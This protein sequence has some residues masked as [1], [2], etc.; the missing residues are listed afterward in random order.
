MRN[1]LLILFVGVFQLYASDTYSQNTRLT[2]DLN[3]VPVA[4]VLEKI[5][6]NSEFYFLYNAKLVD[7]KREVSII[8]K[9][10]KICDI[11]ASLFSGTGVYYK[12]FDRQIILTPNE[13]TELPATLPQQLNITGKVTDASTGEPMPGVNIQVKG[14]TLGTISDAEG[15]YSLSVT[16]RNATL[17]FSF[18]GYTNQEISLNGRTSVDVTLTSEVLGLEEVIVIGYGTVKK[19]DLTGSVIRV[20]AQTPTLRSQAN[21]Q[22]TDMISGSVPGFYMTQGTSASGGASTLE[23]RGLN[24]LL[25]NTNPLF[26]VDGVIYNGDIKDI[27]P[28]DIAAIDILKDASASAVFGSRSASGVVIITTTKGEIGK[29]KISF[30]S[31]LGISESTRDIKPFQGEKYFDFKQSFWEENVPHVNAPYY[32]TNPYKLPSGI[33]IDEWLK[34]SANPDADPTLEWLSRLAFWP[35]EV[36]NYKEGKTVDWYDEVMQKGI[37]QNYDLSITGGTENVSYYWSVGYLNN[38]GIVVGDKFST[39]R[40]RLNVDIKVADFINIGM[41]TQFSDR[42]QSQAPANL[43]MLYRMS[44]YGSEYNIDGT[45]RYLPAEYNP[46]QNPLLEYYYNDV[47]YKTISLNSTLYSQIKLPFGITYRLTF[48]PRFD[49]TQNLFFKPTTLETGFGSR[50][51]IKRCDWMLDNLLK[52]N[53]KIGIHDF[54]L[55]LLYS[56]EKNQMWSTSSSNRNFMPNDLLSYHGL[57]LG[58]LPAVSS[59]DTYSTGDAAMA[60]L[61]YILLEKYFLTLS[62][63]RDGFSAFGQENPRAFFPAFAVAWRISKEDFFK[64]SWI[65]QLKLRLSLGINGNR[66]I[67][68]YSALANLAPVYYLDASSVQIGLTSSN[69][70]NKGL[71]WERTESINYGMDIGLI[72]NRII[73]SVDYYN[74]TTKD[75]LMNRRLPIITGY[76]NVTVNIGKLGNHGFEMSLNTVNISTQNLKWETNLAFSLNRN[77]IRMLFGDKGTYILK[78]ETFTGELPDYTNKWFPGYAVDVVWDYKIEGVWQLDEADEAAKFHLKPGDYKVVDVNGDYLYTEY[79]DKQFLGYTSPRYNIG[80]RNDFTFLKNFTASVFIRADLGHIG[81]LPIAKHPDSNMYGVLNTREVPFWTKDN[82]ESVWPRLNVNGSVY[83]GGYNVYFSRSFVRIQDL[84]LSYSFPQKVC[85]RI[86]LNDLRIFG[87][88]RNLYSFDKWE[89]FDPESGS[90]PMPRIFTIG[91]N[92]DLL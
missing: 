30:S 41:N 39:I 81:S 66:D 43:T 57:G 53:K 83:S 20:N 79:Q 76:Q 64:I 63:R 1:T 86:K 8:A 72:N 91:L 3:S 28:N 42:D 24:S 13:I 75:L 40:S 65:N 31:T 52:W 38:K 55:T 10:E 16:D 37:R 44:P 5:E 49:F 19:N 78:G 46:A 25:A 54:D 60:R 35:T 51:N 70:A 11:L 6:S 33:S 2:L 9:D 90:Q 29:P 15:K 69:L 26:V 21:T 58:S 32:Y 62:I 67:G 14:T 50:D 48:Q 47:L 85:Q 80:L 89:D 77:K 22:L 87:S 34:Y 4:N 27:N 56:T 17:E 92:F 36:Q 74:S 71:R 23:L 59:N 7:V 68:I 73:A 45:L 82:P 84:S 18:I 12:V 88:I 61:N